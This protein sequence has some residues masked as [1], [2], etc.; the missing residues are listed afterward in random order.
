MIM[1]KYKYQ[2]QISVKVYVARTY[3]Q[4]NFKHAVKRNY[5]KLYSRCFGEIH[6]QCL[7]RTCGQTV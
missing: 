1:K 2:N 7:L 4:V 5:P 3:V 6:F